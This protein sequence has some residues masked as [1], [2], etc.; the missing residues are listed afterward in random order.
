MTRGLDPLRRL[1]EARYQQAQA[2]LA[3][4]RAEEARLL[5]EG[6]SLEARARLAVQAETGLEMRGYGGGGLWQGWLARQHG[7]L[8]Q[9][10]A[11]LAL[12]RAAALEAL[13]RA[14]GERE[15]LRRI[16]AREA[17]A[18]KR[19]AARAAARQIEDWLLWP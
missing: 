7:A 11:Q 13:R 18:Q 8:Q 4:L 3:A 16:A 1:A 2:R 9:R 17:D 12:E 14:H 19:D 15:A 5:A 6:R 10:F